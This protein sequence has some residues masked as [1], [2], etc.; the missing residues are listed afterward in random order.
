[1]PEQMHSVYGT[2]EFQP[3]QHWASSGSG[4]YENLF[5]LL[6]CASDRGCAKAEHNSRSL[7]FC[8]GG[9]VPRVNKGVCWIAS[10]LSTSLLLPRRCIKEHNTKSDF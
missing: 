8:R 6:R 9:C 1:M 4:T 2:G 7:G 10:G 3:P 5:E